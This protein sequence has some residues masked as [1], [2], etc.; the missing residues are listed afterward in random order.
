MRRLILLLALFASACGGGNS[1]TSPTPQAAL[2]VSGT[3]RGTYASAQIGFG[4][5]TLVL[6]QS[7]DGVSG[8]WSTT[9]D[10]GG[11]NGVGA[12]TVSG[13]LSGSSPQSRPISLTMTPSDPRTCP[14]Q[15][16][17]TAS[18]TSGVFGQWVATN[19]TVTASGSLILSR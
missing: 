16:T 6:T 1:P 15:F 11:G 4:R 10:P 17:G 12:G 7:G 8:N 5:A 18:A 19:C 3:W 13:F 9:P 2:T 14:F